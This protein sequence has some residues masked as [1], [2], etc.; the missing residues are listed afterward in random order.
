LFGRQTKN[1][2]D[3]ADVVRYSEF[4]ASS[5]AL[6]GINNRKLFGGKSV[7]QYRDLIS[8]ELQPV[9]I[10]LAAGIAII[11]N[12]NA[13]MGSECPIARVHEPLEKLEMSGREMAPRNENVRHAGEN[14]RDPDG[15]VGPVQASLDD[16]RCQLLDHRGSIEDSSD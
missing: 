14:R 12:S 6:D 8:F 5:S 10:V 3:D 4:L 9:G 16:F 1:A 7:A 11:Q 15:N 2:R 13:C